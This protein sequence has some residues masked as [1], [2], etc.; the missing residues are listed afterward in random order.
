M[1]RIKTIFA[2]ALIVLSSWTVLAQ[3][4]TVTGKTNGFASN[5]L[6][7]LQ[8]YYDGKT[9]K[10][11]I[12]K[13]QHTFSV[14]L[15]LKEPQFIEIKSGGSAVNFIYAVPGENFALTIDKPI[16]NEAVITIAD[17]NIQKLNTVMDKLLEAVREF[18]INTKT[19]LWADEMISRPEIALKAFERA[20]AEIRK[21][22]ALIDQLAPGFRKDFSTFEETFKKYI[23]IDTYSLKEIEGI[24]EDISKSYMK[25]TALTIPYYRE[26]LVDLTNAYAA[27]KLENYDLVIDYLKNGYITQTIA[28]EAIVKYV[29]NKSVVNYLFYDKVSRELATNNVKHQKYLDFLFA[30]SSKAVHDAFG[31]RYEDMK[32]NLKGK[33][34]NAR[35]DAKDFEFHDAGGKL[36]HLADFRGKLLFIDFWA[37]WCAPCKVQMPYVRDLE[38]HY[39]GKDIVFAKVS[40]DAS[41]PAWLKGIKD[42]NLEGI[43][44]HAKDNFKNP[45]PVAYGINSIPR[46]MLIDSEGKIISDNLP[47]PQNTKE[48]MAIIDADLYKSELNRI[49]NKHLQALGVDKLMNGNGYFIKSMQSLMGIEIDI[50]TR[51]LFPEN[52]RYD[53][54]PR[55]NKTLFM[56]LGEDFFK[57]RYLV[58]RK[59]TV[60][61]TVKDL[62]K[63]AASWAGKLQGLDLFINTKVKMLP[64]DFAEENSNNTENQYVLKVTFPDKTEKYY[65]DKSDFL[66]KKMVQ[67]ASLDPRKGGGI[68]EAQYKYEDYKNVNGVMIPHFLTLNN[69]ISVKVSEAEVKPM[70][71][72]VFNESGK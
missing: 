67:I 69:L 11:P 10:I 13:D 14:E 54:T 31:K 61:G 68:L 64:V 39:A 58:H 43:V 9:Q 18:G 28:S 4:S 3:K 38:K 70:D 15:E 37:S 29:P 6:S 71:V 8:F 47:K 60:F 65:I 72:K 19:K 49:L 24:L 27:R 7:E 42:E 36:Y 34:N 2:F 33:E 20:N 53:Y 41:E 40:L 52:F 51:Y 21:N 35:A 57:S 5:S 50:E 48:L 62:V 56:A 22:E 66:I 32:A 63:S 45:F 1:K 16:L 23:L 12:D 59:D 44:L 17:G 30:N 26:F 46:F 55:E 25:I